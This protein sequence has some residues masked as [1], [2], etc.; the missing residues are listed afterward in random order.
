MRKWKILLVDDEREFVTTLA[1]RLSLRNIEAR[2]AFDGEDAL[3]QVEIEQPDVMVLD[4]MM[5]GLGGLG[6]LERM[7]KDYPEVRVILLTGHGSNKDGAEG[8]RLGA[9]DY[10]MKP[11][12]IQELI[13]KIGK[14][15]EERG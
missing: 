11:L 5:P 15:I 2:L 4:L 14:A 9:F 13:Q 8:V 12:S 6:V 3:K 7:R 1:E 10:L